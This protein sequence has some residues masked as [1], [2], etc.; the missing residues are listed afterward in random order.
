MQ[1]EEDEV[2]PL[3]AAAASP[4]VPVRRVA[5]SHARPPFQHARHQAHVRRVVLDVQHDA[6]GVRRTAR[7]AARRD[8]SAIVRVDKASVMCQFD[9]EGRPA[10]DL[11]AHAKRAAHRLGET[12]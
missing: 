4:D 10:A 7:A 1:V 3:L 12:A 8:V 5:Q 6:A 11:A 2:G 9:P